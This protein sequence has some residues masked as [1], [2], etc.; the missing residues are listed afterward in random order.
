MAYIPSIMIIGSG[1]QVIIRVL[2]VSEVVVLVLL[3]R[4]SMPM[5]WPE[6]I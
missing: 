5:R 6:V 1:I 4:G 2:T 3:M